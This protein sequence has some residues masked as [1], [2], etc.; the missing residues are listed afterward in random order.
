MAAADIICGSLYMA[1]EAAISILDSEADLE[2]DLIMRNLAVDDVTAGFHH[3]EPVQV[4]E[5]LACL[6]NG[7]VDGVIGAYG[8][9]TDQ[10]YDL[11]GMAGH[12]VLL[13]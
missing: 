12:A 11:V 8:R 10:F 4:L 6:A 13:D 9:G 2:H 1:A 5:R 7:I 3:L